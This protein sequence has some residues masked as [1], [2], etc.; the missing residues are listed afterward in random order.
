MI[1]SKTPEITNI[2]F[3]I[4]L[5]ASNVIAQ[6]SSSKLFIINSLLKY[7]TSLKSN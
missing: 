6:V 3:F 4:N 5:N 7:N 2:S 1:N